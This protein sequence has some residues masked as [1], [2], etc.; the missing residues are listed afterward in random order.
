MVN[1]EVARAS[2]KRAD[3]YFRKLKAAQKI[4]MVNIKQI[5][6][7]LSISL[8]VNIAHMMIPCCSP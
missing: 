3:A 2:K 1:R 7:L 8:Y 5:T 4:D 6:Q